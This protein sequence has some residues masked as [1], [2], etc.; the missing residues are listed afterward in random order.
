MKEFYVPVDLTEKDG[1]QA[2]NYSEKL[3]KKYMQYAPK[4]TKIPYEG[5]VLVSVI[6][7]YFIATRKS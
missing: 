6:L 5:M 4:E 7:F 2:L 3:V 1:V